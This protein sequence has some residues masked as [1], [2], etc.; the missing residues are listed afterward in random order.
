[1]VEFGLYE[2]VPKADTAGRRFITAKWVTVRKADGAA[3]ARCVCREFKRG[4]KRDD[5]FAL[6]T[7]DTHGRHL[8]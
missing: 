4:T 2:A 6:Q 7:R 1:M 8:E 3:R 5:L